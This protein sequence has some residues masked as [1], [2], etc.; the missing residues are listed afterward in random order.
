MIENKGLIPT[1]PATKRMLW[2]NGSPGDG[3]KKLPPT[4]R[5]TVSPTLQVV[6]T[7]WAGAAKEALTA[8]SIVPSSSSWLGA[9]LMEKPPTLS[10][11][12]MKKSTHWPAAK[13][14]PGSGLSTTFFT[15]GDKEETSITSAAAAP[16]ALNWPAV[17]SRWLGLFVWPSMAC[18]IAWGVAKEL[19]RGMRLKAGLSRLLTLTATIPNKDSDK[20]SA[21]G[22]NN[23]HTQGS[24]CN[25]I[26]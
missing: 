16:G 17:L 24:L 13:L 26:L 4:L 21:V 15:V 25:C 6:C 10:R 22:R 20:P 3:W 1:P 11:P 2:G 14:T 9:E 18:W 8:R 7:Q 19:R 23:W 5:P 12:G